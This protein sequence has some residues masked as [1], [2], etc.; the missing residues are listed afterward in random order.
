MVVHDLT[1]VQAMTAAREEQQRQKKE[2]APLRG[3][4]VLAIQ[5]VA[6]AVAVLVALLLRMAGGDAYHSLRQSFQQA[7]TR[8]EWVTA[9]AVLWDGDPL[10]GEGETAVKDT[11]KE[12]DFTNDES[13]QLAGSDASVPALAP[14]EAGI[15]TSVYGNRVHPIE[16]QEE[17]HTGVDI[18]APVGTALAAVYDGTVIDVGEDDRLGKYI[19]LSHRDGVEVLYGHCEEVLAE[20]GAV[21]RA[22]ERVALVGS[23][24]V[25]TG[26]HVHIRV[27]VDGVTCNPATLLP[28]EKYA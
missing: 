1:R 20:Q 5:S 22:G 27:E 15:I 28:L 2:R 3:W 23:T 24:G 4:S 9:W 8:N 17:F 19:R 7:L 25:S 21:V 14:L 6:C 18:A 16:G 12:E 11:V 26:S 13:A 10:E